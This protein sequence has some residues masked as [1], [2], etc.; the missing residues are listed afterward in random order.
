MANF[1][2]LSLALA[3]EK[4]IYTC[5]LLSLPHPYPSPS[6]ERIWDNH[7]YWVKPKILRA[8]SMRGKNKQQQQ[9]QKSRGKSWNEKLGRENRVGKPETALAL[10]HRMALGCLF[11]LLCPL[12]TVLPGRERKGC[13]KSCSSG[14][15]PQA[16]RGDPRWPWRSVAAAPVCLEGSSCLQ[17]SQSLPAG[18]SGFRPPP[19]P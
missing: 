1:S 18:I 4:H 17:F 14:P 9:Q 13:G 8:L 15:W 6:E 3:L 7:L 16:T 19:N 2:T 11:D 10:A 12:V 5:H